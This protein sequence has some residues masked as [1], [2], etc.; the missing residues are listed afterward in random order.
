MGGVSAAWLDGWQRVR[1]APA[2]LLGVFALTFAAAVPFAVVMRNVLASH[3]GASLEAATAAEGANWNWWQEFISQASGLGATFTPRIVGF[4]ATL[5]SISGILDARPENTALLGLL[6]GYLAL[7]T[8]LQ[9]GIIDRYA[10]Q[11][12]TRAHGFAAASGVFFFRFLRLGVMAGVVYWGLFDYVHPWL[13]H[14]RY[15]D[16]ARGLDTERAAFAW[17]ATFYVLFGL[18]VVAVN[19]VFDYTRIRMVVEDRRS[20]V[21]ALAAAVRF[22][23]RRPGAVAGLWLANALVFLVLAAVW[24]FAAPGVVS[25]GPAMWLVF[26]AAQLFVLA[27]LA[28]KLQF[29]A[30]QTS[31]FQAGL[32]HARYVATPLPRWPESPAV[33]SFSTVAQIAE[34]D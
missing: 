28:V 19:V 4:A 15:V 14:G 9:G 10:R 23:L 31:L 30:S 25:S 27:R 17:R 6:A 21:A 13:F 3:L 32:A 26:L 5:D 11:R 33:E 34:V 8:W 16:L 18:V 12:P 2:I 22:V 29:V 24:A 1:R 20:A 7:W